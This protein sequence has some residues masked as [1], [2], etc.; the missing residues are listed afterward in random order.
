MFYLFGAIFLPFIFFATSTYVPDR[1]EKNSTIYKDDILII[2][3][4]SGIPVGLCFICICILALS[5]LGNDVLTY[6]K[7]SSE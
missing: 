3:L 7:T 5:I 1:G 4:V 6:L 2:S